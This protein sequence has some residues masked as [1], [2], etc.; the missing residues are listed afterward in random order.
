MKVSHKLYYYWWL[1]HT[2]ALKQLTIKEKKD[3][4]TEHISD[5]Y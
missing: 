5:N 4:F 2:T 3:C 1:N